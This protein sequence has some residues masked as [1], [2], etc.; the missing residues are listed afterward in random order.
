MCIMQECF[1]LT[2]RG[3]S[4]IQQ[5]RYFFQFCTTSVITRAFLLLSTEESLGSVLLY[6][7]YLAKCSY[8]TLTKDVERKHQLIHDCQN[9]PLGKEKTC[10]FLYEGFYPFPK[11]LQLLLVEILVLAPFGKEMLS[12]FSQRK[13]CSYIYVLWRKQSDRKMKYLPTKISDFCCINLNILSANVT[14]VPYAFQL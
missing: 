11:L 1:K 4:L 5:A 2:G 14:T 12:Y 7:C 13:Y 10:F 8:T 3:A 9:S 6:C